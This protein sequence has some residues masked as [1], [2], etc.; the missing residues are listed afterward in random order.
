[1]K[2]VVV[3]HT[4]D[5]QLVPALVSAHSLKA[6]SKSPECFDVRILRLEETPQLLRREGQTYLLWEGTKPKVWRTSNLQAFSPLRRM[7]PA[8]LGFTGRALVIDPDVFAVG[9]VWELLSRDMHGKA[10]LC[11]RRTHPRADRLVHSSAV[12]LLDCEKLTDWDWD[13]DLDR[14]FAH[15]LPLDAWLA[16]EDVPP[17]Q[18]GLFEDE[19]NDLDTLTDGTKLL[20]TTV[21]LTQPWKTGLRATRHSLAPQV[22]MSREWRRVRAARWRAPAR[23]RPVED[24]VTYQPHPDPRQEA[25]FFALMKECLADGGITEKTIRVAMRKHWLRKDAL[26][27]LAK[28][29]DG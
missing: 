3:I 15:E 28:V 4:N 8:L 26:E 25:L 14:I 12:M 22:F 2:P 19:W 5:Q 9:D 27:M 20:H 23:G 17:E 16:L 10:I 11:R 13:R 21:T 7:V 24:T 6:R 1:M 29:P 18:I